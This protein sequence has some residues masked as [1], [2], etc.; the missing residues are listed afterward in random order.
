MQA[1]DP[2]PVRT[3]AFQA[4][5]FL[6]GPGSVEG[7][8]LLAARAGVAP[9]VPLLPASTHAVLQ[10][11]GGFLTL[12]F[13]F[14]AHGVPHLFGLDLERSARARWAIRAIGLLLLVDV[15]G[16][17]GGASALV[18][19]ARALLVVA[20]LAFL[21]LLAAARLP[22]PH[23]F[24]RAPVPVLLLALAFVPVGLMLW[25]WEALG[26][27]SGLAGDLL[28]YGAAVPVVLS[29]GFQMFSSMLQLPS[30][31]DGLFFVALAAWLFGAGVRVLAHLES[32]LVGLHAPLLLLGALLWLAALR[33]LRR[34]RD[35]PLLA[36]QP[37][38]FLPAHIGVAALTL[39]AGAALGGWPRLGG[40]AL[41][42]D[43]AR[44]LIAIG[45]ALN[46]T[47]GVTLS[48]LPRFC[49]GR[50]SSSPWALFT[51]VA[52]VAALLLRASEVM[53]GAPALLGASALLSWF[54]VLS[55]A[56]HL[57]RGLLPFASDPDDVPGGQPAAA[58]R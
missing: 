4:L 42:D 34:R 7:A 6:A 10:L 57:G 5:F 19:A 40:P 1:F 2:R 22:R 23:D 31:N 38:A 21:G 43:L 9:L 51:L 8:Q 26:G 36:T 44:H 41:A 39:V 3:A 49:R 29:M 52:V 28:L 25:L 30:A 58:G 32:A 17:L 15:A 53:D 56:L 14:L 11:L 47:M 24:A 18:L 35:G 54:A 55:W 50:P 12:I 45:F 20:A 27:P 37:P 33:G 13:A 46:V 16:E 48:V